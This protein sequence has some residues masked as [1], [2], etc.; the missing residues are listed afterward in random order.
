MFS[1]SQCCVIIQNQNSVNQINFLI[2]G[3][4]I[5]KSLSK[6]IPDLFDRVFISQNY[7]INAY[8]GYLINETS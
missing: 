3:L 5:L 8:N 1:E 4:G 6:K 7:L 2:N